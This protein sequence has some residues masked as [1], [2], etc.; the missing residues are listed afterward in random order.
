M[1][2]LCAL[3]VVALTA[4][5]GAQ[6]KPQPKPPEPK[7]PLPKVAPKAPPP[8][9]TGRAM[10]RAAATVASCEYAAVSAAV[11]AAAQGDTITMPA[12]TCVWNTGLTINKGITLRGQG[13]T[14]V[15][16]DNAPKNGSAASR[17]FMVTVNA[18]AAVRL[19]S[20][21]LDGM[22]ADSAGY[23]MGHIY[24]YGTSK[25]FRLDHI[26]FTNQQTVGVR[27]DGDLWG[28]IDHCSFSGAF[29]QGILIGHTTWGGANFGDGSWAAPTALGTEQ[30]I[31]V[32]DNVFRDY[33]NPYAGAGI[34]I[35]DGGRM[36]IRH[37]Q[38]IDQ[39]L[40]SHGTESGQR[41]RSLR[42]FEIYN[43]TFTYNGS[44]FAAM[45]MRG[46]TG[47]IYSNTVNSGY[48]SFL[49][50]VNFRD[51]NPYPP[52]GKCDGTSPYDQ[53]T[54]GQTGYRCVDQP[55]AGPSRALSGDVPTPQPVNNTSEP[56]YQ[57][58]NTYGGNGS[59]NADISSTH[60]QAG[61]DVINNQTKPGY[62]AYR[63]PHPLVT[64]TPLPPVLTEICGNGIDDDK[65]GQIDENPPCAPPAPA[66]KSTVAVS[67]NPVP[68]NGNQTVNWTCTAQC[69]AKDW[70]GLF[71]ATGGGESF[72][73]YTDGKPAGSLQH[74]APAAA[75]T[76][77]WKY[78]KNDGYDCPT[79]ASFTVSGTPPTDPCQTDPLQAEY[80]HDAA[81]LVSTVITNKPAKVVIEG[82]KMT[83]TDQ[84]G[85]VV[86]K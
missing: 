55:G 35:L 14:T 57:W 20:F 15:I 22:A 82:G 7:G 52:W 77:Q 32:E 37:N 9:P 28:V 27:L 39:F 53:N 60:T 6:M 8:K 38:F 85:C 58:G 24:A 17:L 79:V 67:P 5:L 2:K 64:E 30:A 34:D 45:Y 61:R 11:Q 21:R 71:P 23:N 54:S 73:V 13:D 19:S 47:V 33:G 72:Y 49:R 70:V 59:P 78:C 56:I 10:S 80:V 36:V 26:T 62:V 31:F 44:Y 40:G 74:A 66:H 25:L 12:G 76:H 16:R 46:G 84:R 4:S 83:A 3:V 1:K 69:T 42:Q 29:T 68:P 75:G 51:E 81:G 48:T 50:I 65:D 41:R 63:Y 43:N 86:T 18:P